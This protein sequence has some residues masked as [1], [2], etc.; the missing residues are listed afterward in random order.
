MIIYLDFK[1]ILE[2][3]KPNQKRIEK[4]NLLHRQGNEI[5]L[6]I[7]DPH[8]FL[9]EYVEKLESWG[10]NFNFIKIG[11]PHYDILVDDKTIKS[12]LF[13]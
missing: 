9:A 8:A 4:L 13:F 3:D 1:T 6:W 2:D 7:N 5:H 10:C 12:D 11:K